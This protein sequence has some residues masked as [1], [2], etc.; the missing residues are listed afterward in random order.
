MFTFQT[1]VVSR[2]AGF[3]IES[4]HASH[5]AT[6]WFRGQGRT[7]AFCLAALRTVQ[8]QAQGEQSDLCPV[9]EHYIFR[10]FQTSSLK[11]CAVSKTLHLD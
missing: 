4:P 9:T 8:M 6:D 3:G 1:P 10:D 5:L 11:K 7:A 2:R